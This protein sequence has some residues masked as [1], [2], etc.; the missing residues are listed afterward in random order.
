MAYS[1]DDIDALRSA[2]VSGAKKV[3][4]KDR[5]TEFRD[6]KEMK[7][8]LNEAENA[9]SGTK[10]VAYKPCGYDRGYQ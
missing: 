9:V 8:I 7:Q 3:K 6:L 10:R 2:Y 4:F 5:E 1:Q